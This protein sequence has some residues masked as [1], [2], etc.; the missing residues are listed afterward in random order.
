MTSLR[1][2]STNIVHERLASSSQ[3]PSPTEE[4]DISKLAWD[5][6]DTRTL[7][8]SAHKGKGREQQTSTA[9]DADDDD[10]ETLT[11]DSLKEPVAKYPPMTEEEFESKKVEENLKRWETLE[12]QRRKKARESRSG[13]STT[14]TN[15]NFSESLVSIKRASELFMSRDSKANSMDRQNP[16]Q[17]LPNNDDLTPPERDTTLFTTSPTSPDRTPRNSTVFQTD[18]PFENPDYAVSGTISLNT[19]PQT[20]NLEGSNVGSRKKKKKGKRNQLEPPRPL[21]LPLP[22]TPPSAEERRLQLEMEREQRQKKW[23]TEW[24]CGCREEGEEQAGRTNPME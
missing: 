6:E 16:H 3:P 20:P 11:G 22:I 4:V 23:W 13:A 9:D 7:V 18:N 2:P 14:T 1:G 5:D 8:H 10:T 15:H 21:D 12:K 17:V 24:L 19:P